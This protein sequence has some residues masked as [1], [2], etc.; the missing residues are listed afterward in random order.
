MTMKYILNLLLLLPLYSFGQET[1]KGVVLN[2]ISN[3]PVPF[4]TIQVPEQGKLKG[5]Y[6]NLKGEFEIKTIGDS[7]TISCIGYKTI[8]LAKNNVSKV[9]LETELLKL[10]SVVIDSKREFYNVMLGN[11]TSKPIKASF[12]PGSE[13]ASFIKNTTSHANL[14]IKEIEFNTEKLNKN[15]SFFR[16]HFYAVKNGKPSNEIGLSNDIYMV[17]DSKK[18]KIKVSEQNIRIPKEGLFVS[19]EVLG[20]G[21]SEVKKSVDPMIYFTTKHHESVT[22]YRGV[23]L[24]H[25][26]IEIEKIPFAIK[27]KKSLSM[28]LSI[29]VEDYR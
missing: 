23:L 20:E 21:D 4:A 8:T 28:A 9:L 26:W 15:Q 27:S 19:I 13:I 17:S 18:Q 1:L 14:K 7:I 29:I 25:N 10:E 16:I 24:G 11:S 2:K 12:F 6:T 5:T 22:F 3:E